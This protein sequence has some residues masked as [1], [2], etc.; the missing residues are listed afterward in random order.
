M[1][2][3]ETAICTT[4]N[5]RQK[6]LD[7]LAKIQAGITRKLRAD[8]GYSGLITKN[9][10]HSDWITHVWRAEPYELG[11][12]A[13]YVELLPL[14]TKEREVGLGRNC[15][16]FDEV[17]FWAYKA[18]RDYRNARDGACTKRCSI[19]PKTQTQRF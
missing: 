17:R 8:T 12:L 16:L 19:T 6:P 11:E 1:Y 9:P 5:A 4:D 10:M 3:L 15:D 14:T 2:D 18:V 13:D 7:Y